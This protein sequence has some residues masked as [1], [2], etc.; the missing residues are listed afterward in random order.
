MV[1]FALPPLCAFHSLAETKRP[2]TGT[3]Y[4]LSPTRKNHDGGSGWIRSEGRK[5][6]SLNL[7]RFLRG[8][9]SSICGFDFCSRSYSFCPC[10]RFFFLCFSFCLFISLA[11]LLASVSFV[12][13]GKKNHSPA[14]SPACMRNIQHIV[15]NCLYIFVAMFAGPNPAKDRELA[16]SSGPR[17]GRRAAILWRLGPSRA[18]LAH[19]NSGPARP[20]NRPGPGAGCASSQSQGAPEN[21]LVHPVRSSKALLLHDNY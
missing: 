13:L 3:G 16:A 6:T 1:Y 17:H 11:L 10:C 12:V 18:R 20:R 2:T 5:S 15:L 9:V 8:N 7:P 14:K 21:V 19:W 4:V